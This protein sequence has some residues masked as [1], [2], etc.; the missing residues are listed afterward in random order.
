MGHPNG[1]CLLGVSPFSNLS[2]T[3]E[4]PICNMFDVGWVVYGTSPHWIAKQPLQK[5]YWNV[6][7]SLSWSLICITHCNCVDVTIFFHNFGL[8]Q[9]LGLYDHI[10]RGQNVC[11]HFAS[12]VVLVLCWSIKARIYGV[13]KLELWENYLEIEIN[14]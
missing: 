8:R 11:E 13:E 14:I 1:K 4:I 2:T 12:C 5:L 6:F 9:S 10:S 7:K 3:S